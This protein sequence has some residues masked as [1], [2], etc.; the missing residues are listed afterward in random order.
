MIFIR[1][2]RLLMAFFRFFFSSKDINEAIL[3]VQKEIK[4][5]AMMKQSRDHVCK[6]SMSYVY[7][8]HMSHTDQHKLCK[9][10]LAIIVQAHMN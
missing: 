2:W 9:I 1:I 7:S 6:Y 8:L 4:N 10:N 5:Q 3:I